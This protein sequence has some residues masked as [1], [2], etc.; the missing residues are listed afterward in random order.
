[1]DMLNDDVTFKMVEMYVWEK[2]VLNCI[3]EKQCGK[4]W[5]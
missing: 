4:V 3:V 5:I 1:M 2:V